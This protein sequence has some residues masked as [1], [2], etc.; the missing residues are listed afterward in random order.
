MPWKDRHAEGWAWYHDRKAPKEKEIVIPEAKTPVQTLAVVKEELEMK[1]AQA[2]LEPTPENVYAYIALQR[3][4]INQASYFSS[5]WQKVMLEHPELS[6][7][8]PTSQ[9]G[10][11]IQKKVDGEK[12]DSLINALA[13]QYSLLFLYEGN[14]PYSQAFGLIVR[15]F[16]FQHNWKIQ[17]ISTDGFILRE[18]PESTADYELAKDM[19]IRFFPTL[20]VFDAQKKRAVPVAIGMMSLNQIKDNISLQFDEVV[21][22]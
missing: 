8:K 20:L 19:G 9:Y 18:F 6:S 11:Q 14:N 2:M 12:Q 15:E 22:D 4:W 10:I 1:L 3:Q 13:K 16:G 5:A 21:N 17:P 7:L